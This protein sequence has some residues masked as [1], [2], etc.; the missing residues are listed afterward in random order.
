MRFVHRTVIQLASISGLAA[1]PWRPVVSVPLGAFNN[2]WVDW[3][4][5]LRLIDLTVSA[6]VTKDEAYFVE[7][8]ASRELATADDPQFLG[9]GAPGSRWPTCGE[10]CPA[11]RS[12]GGLADRRCGGRRQHVPPST[13]W[14]P[15]LRSDLA[16]RRSRRSPGPRRS[17]CRSCSYDSRRSFET[18]S[19]QR[20]AL[21][22]FTRSAHVRWAIAGGTPAPT[23][24]PTISWP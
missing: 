5:Q 22:C 23:V 14:F 9:D 7:L 13:P 3:L 16:V 6:T 8:D 1:D 12:H 19:P 15:E 20:S 4:G 17:G 2:K 11:A 24:G 21:P 10:A 18:R